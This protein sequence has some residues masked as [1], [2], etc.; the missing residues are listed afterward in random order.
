MLKK[1]NQT[2]NLSLSIFLY[3]IRGYTLVEMVMTL[4]LISILSASVLPKFFNLTSYQE[5]ALFD[6]TLNAIR[7]AQKLAVATGCNVQFVIASNQ[8]TLKRPAGRSTCASITATDFSNNVAQPAT[9]ANYTGSQSGINLT[10][11]TLYFN[12]LGIVVSS[13]GSNISV[14]ASHAMTLV[15]STGFV[16]DSSP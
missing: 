15:P 4:V 8:F 1:I 14:G 16:Y 7:Y 2:D 6:D 5:K 11:I 3:G 9:G 13:T 10:A 12:A